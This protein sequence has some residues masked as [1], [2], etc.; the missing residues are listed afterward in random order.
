MLLSLFCSGHAVHLAASA[1]REQQEKDRDKDREQQRE[2]DIRERERTNEY[3]RGGELLSKSRL[4][5]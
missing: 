5:E 2:R 3:M 1:E 4:S